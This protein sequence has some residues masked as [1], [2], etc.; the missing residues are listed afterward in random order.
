MLDYVND[1]EPQET[2]LGVRAQ[3]FLNTPPSEGE[4]F[5]A[6]F[7]EFSSSEMEG[8][9]I[10][11]SNTANQVTHTSPAFA[12]NRGTPAPVF[13]SG[14][15]EQPQSPEEINKSYAPIGPDGKTVNI[16]TSPMLPSV[17][18]LVAKAKADEL[19]R[20]GVLSRAGASNGIAHTFAIGLAAFIADPQNAATVF[21]PGFGE[22]TTLA[23]LGKAGITGAAARGGARVVAGAT[24]GAIAQA[25]L[26]ALKY[27]LG[28]QEASDYDLRSAFRDMVFSAA[29]GAIIHAGFGAIGDAWKAR[30]AEKAEKMP[31]ATSPEA[32]T[33]MNADAPTKD[34]AMRSSVS[35]VATGRE[36]SVDPFFPKE[37]TRPETSL[38]ENSAIEN[39]Y[40]EKYLAISP[41]AYRPEEHGSAVI[42]KDGTV[43]HSEGKTH[44]E[45]AELA[46]E[47]AGLPDEAKGEKSWDMLQRTGA[48]RIAAATTDERVPLVFDSRNEFTPKQVS[49][50]REI[51][52]NNPERTLEFWNDGK[53]VGSTLNDLG[54]FSRKPLDLQNLAE[55]QRQIYRE[56]AQP[57]MTSN[58][59]EKATN[60][61]FPKEE[62]KKQEGVEPKL[63]ETPAPADK[64]PKSL[65]TRIA[66]S[67]GL[68]KE[69][70]AVGE[71]SA[72][73]MK[74]GIDTVD[75]RQPEID[76]I[77]SKLDRGGM[78]NEELGELADSS[79]AYNDAV[80]NLAQKMDA[81]KDCLARSGG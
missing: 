11:R 79:K 24:G 48:V 71:K 7:H 63:E 76:A 14:P 59:L 23:A 72:E 46:Y 52:R 4:T 64:A 27:G 80:S 10:E 58:E 61:V 51:V 70:G 44:E 68:A 31:D 32:S 8:R 36:V 54:T 57:G 65:L 47:K 30:N 9:Q 45:M 34:A 28:T 60:E 29:G 50:I 21:I 18:Q 6:M 75:A 20:E 2:P 53:S 67:V 37:E 78:T 81:L 56:G 17:A 13:P 69:E 5:G 74:T 73:A 19:D 55:K 35:Q 39:Y 77:E 3:G 16:T 15:P 25:P 40:R 49:A 38:P 42:L 62:G 12:S 22:E 66:E 1:G 41:S 26:S 43:L 33:I